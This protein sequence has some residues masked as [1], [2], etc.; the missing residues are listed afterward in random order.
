MGSAGG[1]ESAAERLGELRGLGTKVGQMAGLVEANLSPELRAKVGPTLAKLRADAARS[2]YEA[3]AAVIEEDFG[4][5]PDALF[6]EFEREPFASASLG[7]VHR[8]THADGRVLAVKVQHPGIRDAFR[9]DLES[10]TSIGRI[11]TS[12]MMPDAQGRVFVEGVKDGFLA[13]LDYL[14]EAENLRT[15]ARLTAHDRDLE[16]P[17]L[18][19][20]RSSARV[21]T[22]TFLRGEPVE[23]AR[24]YDVAVRK[25]QAAA[26]R[27]LVLSAL[28]DHGVLYAD[29]HAG[30]FLFR[31][32]GTIGVLDFGSVFVF[33]EARRRTFADLRDA[34]A[35]SDRAAFSDAIAALYGIESV[36]VVAALAKVQFIAFGGLVRGERIDAARVR[37]IVD[38]AG[39]MKRELLGERFALPPFLPFLMRALVGTNALLASLDAPASDALGELT[40]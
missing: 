25:R 19:D 27:R 31:D 10:V 17:E 23:H 35:A 33:D 18:I 3:I 30:N 7:Q 24:T 6:A 32:D 13:E 15:F 14:R 8:A 4:A 16:V 36:K 21:L 9:G 38:T 5:P 34:A 28:T 40:G 37:A 11:A 12:F 20:D 26:V 22:T 39:E 2:P 1:I 29:A